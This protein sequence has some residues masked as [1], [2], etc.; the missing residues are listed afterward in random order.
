MFK[1]NSQL[2]DI[3]KISFNIQYKDINTFE[4]FFAE[5]VSA[6]SG[7]EVKSKT[8]EPKPEDIWCFEVYYD[9][10]FDFTSINNEIQKF[11]ESNNLK[12]TGDILWEEI[13]NKDWVALYQNQ[14]S[15]IQTERFFICTKLHQDKCP[16][17]KILILIEASRAFG[18]GNHETT[19]GCIETLEYIS[20]IKADKILDIGTGSGIL[21]F[22]AEK[23]WN[24][25]EIFAC[26]IDETSIEIAKENAGFNNSNVN[27]YQNNVD[28]IL[29][30]VYR[31]NKF[32]LV[33]SN[34]L[35]LPLIEN[36]TQIAD[37]IN[38][39]GYL[40]L[41]GFL[42]YQMADVKS[43]YEEI[44][45]EVKKILYKNSWVILVLEFIATDH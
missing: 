25:A 14:L 2:K 28:K 19:F 21:S 16:K 23:L 24:K 4:E 43:V 12:I 9:N 33:V 8:I 20:N 15:P 37:L 26:D 31:H 38:K 17:D 22:V 34:I 18:T 42:D 30:G 39:N 13:E 29:A 36:S 11:V 3:F 40:I 41:S 1:P 44:G 35:A 5:K 6:T 10:K 45:F 7:Y 32:D 27:F